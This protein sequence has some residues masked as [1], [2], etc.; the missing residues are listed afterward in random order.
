MSLETRAG[1][2]T[3]RCGLYVQRY[4]DATGI[5]G[6]QAPMVDIKS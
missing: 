4:N 6:K 3:L 5:V 1:V 2:I